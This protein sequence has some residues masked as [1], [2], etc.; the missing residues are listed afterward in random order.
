MELFLA[1][2]LHNQNLYFNN[3]DFDEFIDLLNNLGYL[4]IYLNF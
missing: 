2:M 1:K 4:K 3:I